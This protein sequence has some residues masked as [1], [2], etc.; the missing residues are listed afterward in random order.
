MQYQGIFVPAALEACSFA[1]PGPGSLQPLH[2][3][4]GRHPGKTDQPEVAYRDHS[5]ATGSGGA[6]I[7]YQIVGLQSRAI[8]AE[9]TAGA[10]PCG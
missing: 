1:A 3:A 10:R 6:A 9:S 7:G 2:A 4:A 5:V 8:L